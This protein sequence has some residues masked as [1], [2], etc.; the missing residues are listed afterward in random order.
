[1]TI[2]RVDVIPVSLPLRRPHHMA[3]GT[4]SRVEYVI[5]KVQSDQG[6]VGLGE[7]PLE[8]GPIFS[9]ETI[10]SVCDVIRR[11]IAPQ[12]VGTDPVLVHGHAEEWRRTIKRNFFAKAAV[13]MALLDLAGQVAGRPVYDLLGGACRQ[14]IPLSFSLGT[15]NP[16]EE[17]EEIESLLERGIGLYKIKVGFL[18]VRE[19][20]GRVRRI[21]EHFSGR[22]RFRVD[23]N[24]AWTFSEA[25]SV[26][27]A[28]GDLPIDFIEQPVSRQP[29]QL[30][31]ELSKSSPIPIAADESVFGPEDAFAVCQARAA[32]VVSVK[33][34]KAGGLLPSHQIAVICRAAGVG[35]YL[36][37]M[38]E[39]GI[40]TAAALHFGASAPGLTF[41][42]ELV[43]PLMLP[44]S[45]VA[46]A[47][48]VHEGQVLVPQGAG[49][50]VTLDD[51]AVRAY[52]VPV[53]RE[54]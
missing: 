41:G 31:A 46:E 2:D 29:M 27:F 8:Q 35:L 17:I 47:P 15:G 16:D 53:G 44:S 10:G 23:A 5:V 40:G 11:F 26:L 28:L 4:V 52:A 48:L 9:E 18:G 30:M 21:V 22:A 34:Q 25:R 33:I 39:T 37:G 7:A 32:D 51:D 20:V 13:E 42:C 50:G 19:D 45:L 43:G 3:I 54:R 6:L 38:L 24:E 12:L 1:M 36:G 14:G 49:L